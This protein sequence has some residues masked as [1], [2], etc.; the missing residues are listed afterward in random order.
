MR[1]GLPLVAWALVSG[2]LAAAQTAPETPAGRPEPAVQATPAAQPA[3]PAAPL[4]PAAP[5]ED[6]DTARAAARAAVV[7]PPPTRERVQNYR[8]QIDAPAELREALRSRT[9]LGRWRE[10]PDFSAEQMPLFLA[11]G[12]EEA[13]AIAQ[14]A[15]FFS[16]RVQVDL[17]PADPSAPRTEPPTV[18][19]AVD[20]GARTTVSAFELSLQ[21]AAAG[22]RIEQRL[23]ERWP[24]PTGGFFR[25]G[26]WELGKRMLIEQ[27]Q[28][29]GY[30][31]ARFVDSRARVD[32][33]LTAAQLSLTLDSGPR[34]RMGALTVRGLQRYPRS[35]VD[36]L[37]PFQEGDPY[38]LDAVLLFQQRLRAAGQFS[39]VTVLPD[40]RALEADESLLDVPLVVDLG[41]RLRQRVTAG[42]GYSTDQGA[43]LLAGYDHR[44]LL[45]RGWVLESGLLLE[46]VRGRAF[47]NVRTPQDDDGRYWQAGLRSERLDTL[48]ELTRTQT[49]YLGRGR[50]DERKESFVSV[51]YQSELGVTDLGA[52]E[53]TRQVRSA[54]TLGWAWS[55]RQ[56]DSRVDP[57]EGYSISTQVSASLK[58][59][60]SDRSFV[61]LYGRTMRFWP[62]SGEGVLARGTLVGLAEAGWVVASDRDDIP[63]QNLFRAGGGQSVRGYRYLGLGIA[64]GDAIVGGR[65]LALGSLEYQ[66]PVTGEW[67][68]AAFVDAGNVADRVSDWRP[69]FGYGGGAR[70]RSPI[71]PV[72]LDLAYG[73]R[74][75]RW[76]LHFSFGYSF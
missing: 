46:S 1:C 13:L 30:L 5:A 35:I 52:G 66:I 75:R 29:E 6:E 14:A 9:L 31:R 49:A 51:Q 24:L 50:R 40:L 28:S 33:E 53:Q 25:T 61:R 70:W 27:L 43:R 7:A 64:Q 67:W 56:L 37:R 44:N 59:V 34:L 57:R 23:L 74:D 4:A 45:E 60:A 68:G 16:A 2:G 72:N 22:E 10:D 21:G 15:G 54:L 19:L 11:R 17:Q 36:D 12:Q 41:E 38:T 73:E 32:V 62:I 48:G 55:L 65:V 3:A 71:G 58:G 63:S 42:L 47:A 69:V 76:R 26:D 18:L 39:S 8:L 20:A